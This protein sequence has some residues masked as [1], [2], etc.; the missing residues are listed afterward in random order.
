[1]VLNVTVC[2]ASCLCHLFFCDF[3]Q[4][5]L[6]ALYKHTTH[7][8]DKQEEPTQIHREIAICK[9]GRKEKRKILKIPSNNGMAYQTQTK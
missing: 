8:P 4:Q 6:N 5:P 9:I 7:Q 3:Y 1:M 2:F